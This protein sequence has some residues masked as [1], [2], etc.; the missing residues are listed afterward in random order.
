MQFDYKMR[1]PVCNYVVKVYRS[2]L[3][4]FLEIYDDIVYLAPEIDNNLLTL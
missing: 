3:T 1:L 4:D 2:V